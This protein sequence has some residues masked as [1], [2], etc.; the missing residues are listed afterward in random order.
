MT[1]SQMTVEVEIQIGEKITLRC[2]VQK[3]NINALN[4]WES[5]QFTIVDQ[6][7]ETLRQQ[8]NITYILES[9]F[10]RKR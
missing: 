5:N 2:V 1:V 9:R 4:F 8:I 3:Q 6:I 7:E 10:I